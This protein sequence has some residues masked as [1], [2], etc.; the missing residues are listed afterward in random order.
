[1]KIERLTLRLLSENCYVYYNDKECILFDPGSDY[2]YINSFLESKGLNVSLILLTHCHFDHIGAVSDLKSKYNA[3]VLCHKDDLRNL[4]TANRSMDYYGLGQIK[5]P[6]I[7]KYVIDNEIIPFG[8]VSIKVIHTPGH[9]AGS[10]CY[11][12]EQDK[13]LVS[14]DTLFLESVGR[15]DFPGGSQDDLVDSIINKLYVLPNDTT[16]FP[17]HGFHTTIGHEKEYNPYI[18]M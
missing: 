1:M 15:T 12:I 13:I 8:D 7:D 11:Y 9:S 16:V 5:I 3:K 10:V 2:E 6:E 17:G 18:Q 4:E 14:G